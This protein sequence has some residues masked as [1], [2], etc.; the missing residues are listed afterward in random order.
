MLDRNPGPVC[1]ARAA[2]TGPN[3]RAL[4]QK[5]SVVGKFALTLIIRISW[6]LE[7]RDQLGFQR[8]PMH[9]FLAGPI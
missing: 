3:D 4:V 7:L 2:H 6:E 8:K 1:A 9:T 5:E